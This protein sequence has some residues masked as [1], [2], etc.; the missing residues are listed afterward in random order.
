MDLFKDVPWLRLM[1]PP[2]SADV[3]LLCGEVND[4][5]RM[6][7]GSGSDT[8]S[9]DI[10]EAI[11]IALAQEWRLADSRRLGWGHAFFMQVVRRNFFQLQQVGAH[12]PQAIEAH[13]FQL[14]RYPPI[15]SDPQ[16]FALWAECTARVVIRV[17]DRSKRRKAPEISEYPDAIARWEEDGG[18][19]PERKGE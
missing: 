15:V 11:V 9:A 17:I 12:V 14:Q 4:E 19:V 1:L 2:K 5:I 6:A 10:Y 13:L 18:H 7:G 16:T 8:L 3:Q